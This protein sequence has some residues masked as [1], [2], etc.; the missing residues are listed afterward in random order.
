MLLLRHT[1][2]FEYINDTG[3]SWEYNTT[4]FKS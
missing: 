1:G 3:A 4:F 2:V